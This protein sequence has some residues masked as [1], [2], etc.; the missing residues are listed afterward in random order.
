MD[1]YTDY[2]PVYMY[3][4]GIIIQIGHTTP[5][6]RVMLDPS[7]QTVDDVLELM[8]KQFS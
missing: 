2:T 6:N 4:G 8:E 5:D 3:F 1:D 7:P